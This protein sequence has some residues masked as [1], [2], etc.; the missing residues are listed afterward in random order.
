MPLAAAARLYR[1]ACRM[2]ANKP[3]DDHAE[4]NPSHDLSGTISGAPESFLS[5]KVRIFRPTRTAS[6]QGPIPKRWYIDFGVQEQWG[7][8]LMGWTSTK[9]NANQLA[10]EL[11]FATQEDAVAFAK[12]QGWAYEV[13]PEHLPLKKVKSYSDNFKY[14]P[15]PKDDE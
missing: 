4:H 7:N 12:S 14:K 9:D 11:S 6:Q 8:P 15:L 5:K 3:S 2:L 1:P 13:Q 10:G